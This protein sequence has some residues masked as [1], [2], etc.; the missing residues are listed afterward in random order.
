MAGYNFKDEADVQLF[1]KNLYTEYQFGCYGEKKGEG[2]C[3]RDR[4]GEST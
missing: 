3:V 2:E 4:A 1:L